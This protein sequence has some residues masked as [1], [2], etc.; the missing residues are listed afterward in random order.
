MKI[1]DCFQFFDENMML[2]LRLNILNQHVHKFIIVENAYMHSGK[3][4]DPVFD[5][6]NFTKF[7]DKI[8]YILVDRLPEGLYDIDKIKN[9]HDVGNRI[10]DNT[11]KIEH[12]QRNTITQGLSEAEDEDLIIISDVDEIPNLEEVDFKKIKKKI[13]HFKQK[14]FYYKFNLKYG[15]IPWF[16]SRACLKKNL[17]SPQ[18]LRDTK[19][20]KYPFWRIDTFFSKS[21]YNNIEYIENGG[22]HFVNIKSPEEIEKKL[23]NFG[24]HWEYQ[25]SGLNLKDIRNMVKNKTA[26]YDY[27]ADMKESK[28]SGQ[29]KLTKCELA[30]LPK[31]LNLNGKIYSDWIE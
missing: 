19:S 26:V 29:E 25:V 8:I 4:K 6:Q 24:H 5:I 3:K 7:K 11:L 16:G 12:A 14:M 21:K 2:N 10:I 15:S 18:W 31:F 30:E 9:A 23:K 17:I 27:H 20:R 13:I 28:W 1:F 22:W